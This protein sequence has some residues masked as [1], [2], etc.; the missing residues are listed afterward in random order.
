M[1]LAQFYRNGLY[2][3]S[4]SPTAIVVA[5]GAVI[6]LILL[7]VALMRRRRHAELVQRFGAEYDR[8]VEEFGSKKA[9][10]RELLARERRVEG[11]HVR[12]L[13]K[14]QRQHVSA[15]WLKIQAQFVDNPWAAIRQASTLI[16]SV[17]REQGY[18]NEAFEQRLADLS[19]EHASVIQHYRA[20]RALTETTTDGQGATEDLRQAMVH[21]RAIVEELSEPIAFAA[22]AAAAWREARSST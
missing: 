21:Y 18:S 13:N 22:A 1:A 11:L 2:G 9:A 4:P 5:I 8:A 3:V 19:V 20:A 10:D 17:M 16:K 6:A 14:R 12:P 7:F 15:Q